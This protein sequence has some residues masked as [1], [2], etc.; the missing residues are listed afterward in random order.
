MLTVPHL[1]WHVTHSCNFTCQGCGHFTNDGYRQNFTIDTLKEWYLFWNKRIRP[2]ELSMLGGEPLLNK[3]IVDIIYMTKEI[4]SI[5]EDQEF[6]LVSN[7]ILFDRV[8]NLAKALKETNCIL[9]ITRHSDDPNYVKLYEKS[10]N[11]IE[12]SGV[13]Y[14]V[15][16]APDFWLKAY[17]GYGPDI[18]PIKSDNYVESWNNCA[19]GQE[20]F[21]LYDGK[22]YKCAPMAYLP[23]QKKKYGDKLSPEWNPY[24]K[25][26]PLE[27][28]ASDFEILEF[29]LR[30]HEPVCSMC[31]KNPSKFKKQS[32]LHSPQYTKK[33]YGNS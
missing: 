2:K 31:P 10:I 22:I 12:E 29:F 9:T 32:P 6:E 1:E 14:R 30:T 16:N 25:Y 23:L 7:G 4:W 3:E 15:Y 5:Q 18:K 20:N 28:S 21:Q 11:S 24:L 8:D 27:S 19:A 13:K 33:T 26:K 17:I